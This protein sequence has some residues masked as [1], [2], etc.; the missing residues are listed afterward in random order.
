M[1][2]DKTCQ[3]RF[4]GDMISMLVNGL[5]DRSEVQNIEGEVERA[6]LEVCGLHPSSQASANLIPGRH[7]DCV[8]LQP[9]L[10]N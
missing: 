8:N 4:A 2:R 9:E 10:Q 5:L 1:N 3:L 6:S 7:M